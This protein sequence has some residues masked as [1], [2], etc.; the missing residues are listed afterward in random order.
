[1]VSSCGAHDQRQLFAGVSGKLSRPGTFIVGVS[2][3]G[4][5]ESAPVKLAASFRWSPN[6][7]PYVGTVVGLSV[8]SNFG[9]K[10]RCGSR[11]GVR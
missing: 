8:N 9:R 4:V 1:M 2:D 11:P 3:L 7:V 6:V 10:P 5:I